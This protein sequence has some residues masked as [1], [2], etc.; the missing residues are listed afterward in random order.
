MLLQIL[1]YIFD[2]G[3]ISRQNELWK[4]QFQ[5]RKEGV[6]ILG[7]DFKNTLATFGYI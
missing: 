4:S 1:L 2:S 7:I 6:Q 3:L 5:H